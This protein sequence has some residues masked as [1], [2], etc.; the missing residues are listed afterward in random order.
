MI[1]LFL[2]V[3]LPVYA[4][5]VITIPQGTTNFGPIS[6]KV[7]HRY[8]DFIIERAPSYTNPNIKAT[9]S[10]Y[11]SLDGKTFD[12]LPFCGFTMQGG[13]NIP[14]TDVGCSLPTAT[15]HIKGSVVVTGGS[16]TISKDMTVGT[17]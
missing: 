11:A 8:V 3:A 17:K 4:A 6:V 10:I 7:V 13:A 12:T 15:T 9:V 14:I 16:I 1:S 5:Q 2:L